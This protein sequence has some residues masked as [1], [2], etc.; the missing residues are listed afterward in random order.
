MIFK[1]DK[2]LKNVKTM[3]MIAFLRS[4]GWIFG[5]KTTSAQRMIPP[6][7]MRGNKNTYLAIPLPAYEQADDFPMVIN[8]VLNTI[9]VL[10][11]TDKKKLAALFSQFLED[12]KAD[13]SL[14]KQI[15]EFAG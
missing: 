5:E 9:A 11:D 13:L 4:K 15:L 1:Y 10:Y 2:S 7:E 6:I 12:L 3:T 8:L 14:K